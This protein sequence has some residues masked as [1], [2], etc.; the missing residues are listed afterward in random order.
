MVALAR[1]V[2]AMVQSMDDVRWLVQR[3]RQLYNEWPGP[4]ELRAVYTYDH[5]PED[6]VKAHSEIYQYGFPG[7]ASE[8][9]RRQ[10]TGPPQKQ[11]PWS[12]EELAE[13]QRYL[14]AA[15]ARSR[16]ERRLTGFSTPAIGIEKF[17][18]IRPPDEIEPIT[19]QDIERVIAERGRRSDTARLA[20]GDME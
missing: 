1:D 14:D 16:E 5:T 9:W 12:E 4:M 7:G 17:S 6:G 18:G 20:A 2:S 15:A 10:L 8:D 3:V 11:Q 13:A 19:A